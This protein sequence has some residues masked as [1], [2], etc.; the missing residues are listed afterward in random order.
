MDPLKF[1]NNVLNLGWEQ[2]Y[3]F[4]LMGNNEENEVSEYE[5]LGNCK[6]EVCC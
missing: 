5:M 6:S 4:L 1:H 2:E 3:V